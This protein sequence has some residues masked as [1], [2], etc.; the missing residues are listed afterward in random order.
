MWT[1]YY[2]FL[3]KKVEKCFVIQMLIFFITRISTS[4]SFEYKFSCGHAITLKGFQNIRLVSFVAFIMSFW[5]LNQKKQQKV[6]LWVPY[7]VL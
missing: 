4:L 7:T 2:I 1:F 3:I 6:E 5:I